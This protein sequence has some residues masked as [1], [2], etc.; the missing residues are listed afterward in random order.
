LIL[1]CSQDRHIIVLI[2]GQPLNGME[3]CMFYKNTETFM[4]LKILRFNSLLGCPLSMI[5]FV[6]YIEP[7]LRR[8]AEEARDM[9]VG[10]DDITALAYADD[11][12]Y[13]V[14]D[15]EE[16]DRMSQAISRFCIESNA[17]V[18]YQK[19]SFLRVNKCKLDPQLMREDSKLKV[20]GFIFGTDLKK[21][22]ADKYERI[23]NTINFVINQNCR[24]N[25][26]LVQ[27]VWVS[28][29]FI[30]ANLWYIS[31]IMPPENL[32]LGKIKNVI[33]KFLWF[34]YLYKI[35]RR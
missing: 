28:N 23:I 34:G 14:Q 19:S 17:K 25:L 3:I 10:Q 12:N 11:I 27:K 26:N 35:D 15:D 32:H 30:L 9:V 21:T 16:C 8:I 20:L 24:R 4:M 7:L 33:G 31:Q 6:I 2:L 22:T 18:N 1:S 13:I 29:T 5:L